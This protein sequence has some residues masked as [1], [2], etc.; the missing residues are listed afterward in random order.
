M[1]TISE[2]FERLFKGDADDVLAE[3]RG[4]D[5]RTRVFMMQHAIARYPMSTTANERIKTL[6]ALQ[7]L[8]ASTED[9]N[10][11]TTLSLRVAGM[12]AKTIRSRAASE[13]K[14]RAI[15][16]LALVFTKTKTL[17]EPL[18]DLIRTTFA[19]ALESND[20]Y[21]SELAAEALTGTGLLAQRTPIGDSEHQAVERI[22]LD[23]IARF[24]SSAEQVR[25]SGPVPI[26]RKNRSAPTKQAQ[27]LSKKTNRP[28]KHL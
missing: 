27:K 14:H 23:F 21:M 16:S 3:A 10:L 13:L 2:L 12:L 15:D 9:R 5:S 20:R 24:G 25:Y 22:A 18:D 4:L 19:S 6:W 17:S 1:T 11:S 26:I 8:L 28:T 7:A